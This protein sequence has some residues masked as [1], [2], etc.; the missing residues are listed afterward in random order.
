MAGH[1]LKRSA[2]A[3]RL[4]L[5]QRIRMLRLRRG[6]SQSALAD[7]CGI[8]P[9]HLGKIERGEANVTIATLLVIA[10]CFR[11]TI[12]ELFRGIL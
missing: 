8:H 11:I 9:H 7:R 10:G 3:R 2:K 12:S 5:G 6:W 1:Y 4:R